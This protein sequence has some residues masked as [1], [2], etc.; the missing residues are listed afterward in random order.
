MLFYQV[1]GILVL[2]NSVF[3]AITPAAPILIRVSVIVHEISTRLNLFTFYR[4]RKGH[5][6]L[7]WTLDPYPPAVC[8]SFPVRIHLRGCLAKLIR[9]KGLTKGGSTVQI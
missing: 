3:W 2:W 4:R 8:N 7:H 9:R 6:T 5:K 1:N